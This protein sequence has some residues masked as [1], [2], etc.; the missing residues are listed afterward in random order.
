[1]N[2][3]LLWR[4]PVGSSMSWCCF[5]IK[6]TLR[7]KFA[8]QF[9]ANPAFSM[10]SHNERVLQ[11]VRGKWS[12]YAQISIQCE[13]KRNE[14]MQAK[15]TVQ[16]S[17]IRSLCGVVSSV[18]K[19][20]QYKQM[21]RFNFSPRLEQVFSKSPDDLFSLSGAHFSSVRSVHWTE[22]GAV[23]QHGFL[24]LWISSHGMTEESRAGGSFL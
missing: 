6:T 21:G 2:F 20:T 7:S 8:F 23:M 5:K 18:G 10:S 19:P 24:V 9:E 17:F 14:Q 12:L 4:A 1:M 13:N 3:R 16:T 22:L 15:H 11:K